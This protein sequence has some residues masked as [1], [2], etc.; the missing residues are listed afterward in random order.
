[1]DLT[2]IKVWFSPKDSIRDNIAQKHF[3]QR[4]KENKVVTPL[5]NQIGKVV[6]L[7]LLENLDDVFQSWSKR[8]KYHCFQ[9]QIVLLGKSHLYFD[10]KL[11][12]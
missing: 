5:T 3:L 2:G 4:I 6:L 7:K 9:V 8:P 12:V 10:P 1:M 11:F